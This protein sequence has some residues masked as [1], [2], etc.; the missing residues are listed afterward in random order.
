MGADNKR[1]VSDCRGAC[2]ARA[3]IFFVT[4]IKLKHVSLVGAIFTADDAHLKDAHIWADSR[5]YDRVTLEVYWV[6]GARQFTPSDIVLT[7]AKVV[8]FTARSWL[9]RTELDDIVYEIPNENVRKP[10]TI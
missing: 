7:G 2:S 1:A 5:A 9:S 3:I 10:S 8:N 4:L 6:R